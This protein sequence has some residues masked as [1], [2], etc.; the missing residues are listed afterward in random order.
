MDA[1]VARKELPQITVDSVITLRGYEEIRVIAHQGDAKIVRTKIENQHPQ[2]WI[3]EKD[4][5]PMSLPL[6]YIRMFNLDKEEQVQDGERHSL[7][8]AVFA[9]TR[10]GGTLDEAHHATTFGHTA[11]LEPELLG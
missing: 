4:R 10:K 11:V 7:F 8:D 9:H 6:A 5:M 1:R 3:I 2:F